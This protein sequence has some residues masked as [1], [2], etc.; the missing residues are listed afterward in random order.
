MTPNDRE[1]R[2]MTVG[3]Q[4]LALLVWALLLA[5]VPVIILVQGSSS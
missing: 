3:K 2:R 5:A 4:Q 1:E